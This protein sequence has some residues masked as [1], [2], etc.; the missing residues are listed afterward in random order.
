[1]ETFATI[2]NGKKLLTI[3]AKLSILEFCGGPNYVPWYS[4]FLQYKREALL[5]I[6]FPGKG[7]FNRYVTL[8]I[9]LRSV[10]GGGGGFK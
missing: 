9:L 8:T 7:T 6:D 10:I 1:M 5:I 3:A 2:V 4:G